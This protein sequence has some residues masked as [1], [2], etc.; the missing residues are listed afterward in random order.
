MAKRKDRRT[1]L[2]VGLGRFG[3]AL[4]MRLTNS[5]AQV[6]AVDKVRARVE[7]LS[8]KLEYVGQLD[9]TDEAALIKI[10]AKMVDVAVICL[11]E[12]IEDSILAT[13]IMKELGVPKIVARAMDD[14]QARILHK[15]GAHKVVSPETEMGR[16][17]AD[18]LENPWM[19][20]FFEF[21]EDNLIMGK[22]PA[23]CDMI[24][25]TL[26]DLELPAKYGSTVTIIE[27]GT[28]KML[29]SANLVLREDD[30]I[31]LFGEKERLAP[32]LDTIE[33]DDDD[34]EEKNTEESR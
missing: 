21:E 20:H 4:A 10:G 11:G 13:A 8:A 34:T 17:V 14:L 32:L 25:K 12:R 23:Q 26:K 15:V 7:E 24:G 31:W 19:N 6:I 22:I 28:K 9:A 16:R 2:V 33:L 3:S 27:R 30:E 29:P 5:G 1:Y 18:L